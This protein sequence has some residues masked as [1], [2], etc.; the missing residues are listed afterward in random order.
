MK[1]IV[2]KFGGSSLASAEQIK[3]VRDIILSDRD[4][5]YVVVSAAGKRNREDDKITDLLIETFECRAD[6][7]KQKETFDKIK[8]RYIEIVKELKIDF[9]IEAE[10]ANIFE[11]AKRI[12]TRDF[13]ASRGEYLSAKVL[14]KYLNC[15]FIDT[16]NVIIFKE[17]GRLDFDITYRNIKEKI[18]NAEINSCES[19]FM[20]DIDKSF[21]VVIPGFYGSKE[22][23]EIVTFSRGGSDITGSLVARAINA[24]TYENWTDVSGVMFADPRIVEDAKPINYITYTELREL[25]YMGATV[26]HEETVYPVSKANIPINIL[27]TNRPTDKGTMIVSSVPSIVKRNV[28][29]GIAGRK[30]FTSILLQ[31]A[32]MNEEIGYLSKL[33]RIFENERIPVEHCP[34]GI[35]TISIVLR[36]EFLND[37]KEIILNK[38]KEELSP[39]I[40]DLEENISLIAVVGEGMVYHKD[41]IMKVFKALADAGIMVKM[42]DQGS[43]GIN[44]I[45]GVSENDHE[46]ALRALGSLQSLV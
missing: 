9:D 22:N 25:S 3:K 16:Q 23:G 45:I 26:L 37:K 44:I 1:K 38:I 31:K 14:S 27:N 24:D 17:D 33:L 7:K 20:A 30:G 8:T 28:I 21:R 46:K 42:I 34:T 2:T 11:E 18:G 19:E 36:S 4:R 41:V 39:D 29:T 43:S 35:D 5:K 12:G 13:L 6:E 10:L 40:L 15:S 32:L